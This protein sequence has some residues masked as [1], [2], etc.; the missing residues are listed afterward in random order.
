MTISGF[1]NMIFKEKNLF[2][3]KKSNMICDFETTPAD[4]LKIEIPINKKKI[5][6][7]HNTDGSVNKLVTIFAFYSC[8][9]E[10]LSWSLNPD[11]LIC[12]L[13]KFLYREFVI[14]PDGSLY[15]DTAPMSIY[16]ILHRDSISAT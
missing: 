8:F 13:C 2:S 11:T 7:T 4:R 10:S 15:R 5:S 9:P 14:A 12:P 3:D 16:Q 1:D 6:A